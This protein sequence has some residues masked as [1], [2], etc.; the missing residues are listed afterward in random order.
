MSDID[1]VKDM[2]ERGIIKCRL[3]NL[4][5]TNCKRFKEK[6]DFNFNFPL[7]VLVGQNGSGK[8]TV[9]RSIRLLKKNYK[10]VCEFF[11]T[12]I[13]NGGFADA[14]FDYVVDGQTLSYQHTEKP[15]KWNLNG[16]LPENLP[17]TSI[18]T[19]S[20]VGGIEKSFL[21]DSI[22]KS[23]KREDQVDYVQRQAHKIQQK[24][25]EGGRKLRFILTDK[26]LA[27]VNRILDSNFVSIE[28]VRHKFFSGTWATNILFQNENSFCEYNSGSGEFLV[29]TI[30][31]EIE[32]AS[33]N[34]I[35]LIDEPEVSLH[36]RAQYK[37]I[38][39]FL[40]AIKRK[41]IQMIV[42]T[43][44]EHIVE[45]LPKEA[46]ICLRKNE[47]KTFVQQ[48]VIPE[49]AFAEIG[50]PV[51]NSKR[52]IVEDDMAQ[53]IVKR[54]LE[55][56]EL[57]PMVSVEFY[58]GGCS[59]L[60]KYTILTYARTSIKNQYIIFDGDQYMEKIP[61]FDLILEKD[62]TLS[63]Y[64]E[65]FQQVVGIR[66][67]T[68]DW[69]LDANPEE[70]RLNEEQEIEQISTYLNFYRTNVCFLPKVIPEDI[71]YDEEYLK[72]ICGAQLFPNL[73]D[74]RDSKEKLF[75]IANALRLPIGGI[76]QL[77][78]TQFI[79]KK[80]EDYQ[81]ISELL[82]MIAEQH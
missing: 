1:V 45:M 6:A 57:E 66:S 22:A 44:S 14:R 40:D 39:Y 26:E 42:T 69:G 75:R 46:V 25:Q 16:T 82:H 30:V 78:I 41:H 72:K 34:S 74:A 70:G 48:N 20:F 71:V 4:S 36:P 24:P 19:K 68:M 27:T 79:I 73:A 62:K 59:N 77:L 58:P 54:V 56:E 31:R 15:R 21:Y 50:S 37:L 80:G 29:A 64:R 8:T 23:A 9:T 43:H 38:E 61:N 65:C 55:E 3:S 2:F 7:T 5:I 32:K 33:N 53:S 13:D 81:K 28:I 60:K 51:W 49:L 11:E 52:I 10:P 76:E 63:F 35:V 17:I 67:S 47:N 12:E 18:Q